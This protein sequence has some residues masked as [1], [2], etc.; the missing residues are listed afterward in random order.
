MTGANSIEERVIE[1]MLAGSKDSPVGYLRDQM[2]SASVEKRTFTGCGFFA[3]FSVPDTCVSIPGEPSLELDNVSGTSPKLEFGIGFIL[4]IR[5]GRLSFLEA[6]TY[7]EPWPADPGEITLT[8][9]P[10]G[11]G[12][13]E[14]A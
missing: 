7:G 9:A 13:A 2:K 12:S 3:D 1:M 11:A 10:E 6:F 4:F 14:L 5:R 8:Y